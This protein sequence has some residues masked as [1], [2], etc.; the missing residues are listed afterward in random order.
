MAALRDRGHDVAWIHL[1]APGSPDRAV[2]E[3]AHAEERILL[4]FDKDF[5]ELAFRFGLSASSGVILFRLPT[6][7]PEY[8]TRVVIGILE[9]RADWI[10]QFAVVEAGSVRL[11]PLPNKR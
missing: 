1:V 3:R 6:P 8:V 5:G 9:S 11:T 4:T 7:S 2:L 10:G